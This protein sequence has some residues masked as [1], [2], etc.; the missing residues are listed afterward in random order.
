M[1][2]AV[3]GKCTVRVFSPLAAVLSLGFLADFIIGAGDPHKI[4]MSLPCLS[5]LFTF[6]SCFLLAHMGVT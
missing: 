2:F 5:L 4:L 6:R 1:V 3:S